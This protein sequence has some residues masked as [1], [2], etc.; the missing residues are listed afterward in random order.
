MKPSAKHL[1]DIDTPMTR[2][3]AKAILALGKDV[4]IFVLMHLSAKLAE[5]RSAKRPAPSAS[6]PS[7]MVPPFQKPSVKKK[8]KAPGA[9]PGHPGAHR[10]AAEPT[11][12]V[13]HPPLENCTKC[14]EPLAAPSERRFRL[15]EDIVEPDTEVVEH[16]IPRQWC[17]KC[18]K[19]V[20][21]RITDALPGMA[22]GHRLVAM[23]AW[24]HYGVGVTISMVMNIVN[25]HL[26]F[27]LSEG[28]MVATW[29]RLAEILYAWYEQIGEEA[30]TAGVL[31]ADETGWRQMGKTVWLW[32]FTTTRSTYYMIHESRGSPALTKFFTQTFAGTL[33]TDFWAAYNAVSAA[34]YQV[35]L[36]H[37]FRELEEVDKKSRS[38][39]WRL[40]SRRLGRVLADALRLKASR[41]KL[42]EAK[43]ASQRDRIN[44]RLDRLIRRTG[45]NPDVFRLQKRLASYREDLFTFLDRPDVP[46]DNNRAEREIRPAVIMRKNSYCN[47]SENGANT[48]AVLMSVFRTLKLRGLHPLNTLVEALRI[49]VATGNLP[50][51][52]P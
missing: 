51:L 1:L 19:L 45:R 32:C 6:T 22:F 4:V 52:P 33:V 7:G 43:Y 44:R 14:G 13:E 9:K 23:T 47:R 12:R 17:A 31:H 3:Q 30:K 16:S 35:C 42:P 36:A 26:H 20:E 5:A 38:P 25:H 48:Q 39:A 10:A 41:E 2:Q 40:F 8:A 11:R 21:P 34:A 24:L 49:Y 15:I 37:L 28:G 27:Q 50:P 46:A 18:R 29:H